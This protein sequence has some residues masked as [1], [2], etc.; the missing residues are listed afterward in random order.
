MINVVIPLATFMH[1]EAVLGGTGT[2]ADPVGITL[3]PSHAKNLQDGLTVALGAISPQ[4]AEL[5]GQAV[6]AMAQ[7][8][9]KGALERLGELVALEV[10]KL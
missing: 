5:A 8:R 1:L 2:D 3:D 4:P 9:D 6:A 7:A 10:A